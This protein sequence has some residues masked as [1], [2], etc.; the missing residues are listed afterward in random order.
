MELF[1]LYNFDEYIR[2]AELDKIGIKSPTV[3]ELYESHLNINLNLDEL[4][5]VSPIDE[6]NFIQFETWDQYSIV[7]PY[8]SADGIGNKGDIRK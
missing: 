1:F 2:V 4:V 6:G 7:V 8:S 3:I 5:K